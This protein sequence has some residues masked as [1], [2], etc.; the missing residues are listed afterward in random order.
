MREKPIR[1]CIIEDHKVVRSALRMMIENEAGMCV[2]GEAA[3]RAEALKAATANPPDVFILDLDLNEEYGVDFLPELLSTFTSAS[4]LVLTSSTDPSEHQRAIKAGA[5]GL[6]LKEEA[7]EVLLNA[8]EK[9][10]S[11]EAWLA[12]SLTAAVLSRVSRARDDSEEQKIRSLT[13]RER[14]IIVLVAQGL[15]RSQI[16][17]KLFLS[18]T[19]V[20]NHLTSI[21]AKLE[22]S[23][24]FELVFYAFRNSLAKP[25]R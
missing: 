15:K 1:V 4:V 10:H 20:R 6:V 23:D 19:T 22:L 18:E 16:A 2:V 11:G 8:T 9:L 13:K 14:E 12:P 7:S 3:N 25:P 24:R 17:E 21:L 5:T